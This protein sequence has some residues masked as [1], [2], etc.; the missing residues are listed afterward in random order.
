MLKLFKVELLLEQRTLRVTEEVLCVQVIR[1]LGE[2]RN[3]D[4]WQ[5]SLYVPEDPLRNENPVA[6]KRIRRDLLE[7]EQVY[8]KKV[9]DYLQ[10]GYSRMYNRNPRGIGKVEGLFKDGDFYYVLQV[11]LPGR[12]YA[13]LPLAEPKRRLEQEL[14]LLKKVVK[15]VKGGHN[16]IDRDGNAAPQFIGD[17]KP[18]NFQVPLEEEELV[19]F[20]FDVYDEA[21]GNGELVYSS[22]YRP[23]L[24]VADSEDA[25]RKNDLT[26]IVLILYERL[27]V[28][29]SKGA[30]PEREEVGWARLPIGKY[31]LCDY[32]EAESDVRF[33][34]RKMFEKGLYRKY[35]SCEELE[36]DINLLLQQIRHENQLKNVP[37]EQPFTVGREDICEAID[38]RFEKNAGQVYLSGVAGIGKVTAALKYAF[39]QK[40]KQNRFSRWFYVE[41]R[42]DI[43]TTVVEEMEF[44][45][46]EVTAEDVD[47]ETV[48]Q[49][50][51]K[52]LRRYG[53]DTL[54]ILADFYDSGKTLK[55]LRDT[56]EFK[57]LSSMD[58]KLLFTTQYN[59]G[60][61]GIEV[62]SLSME[63]CETLFYQTAETK[64]LSRDK[65][66]EVIEAANRHTAV[67][68]R[69]ALV[70]GEEGYSPETALEVIG[71]MSDPKTLAAFKAQQGNC[72]T[73]GAWGLY[74]LEGVK[75]T[76]CEQQVL[77]FLRYAPGEKISLNVVGELLSWDPEDQTAVRKACLGLV[78]AGWLQSKRDGN[79]SMDPLI[80]SAVMAHPYYPGE[81]PL[82]IK[83]I[84]KRWLREKFSIRQRDGFFTAGMIR[85]LRQLLAD[86]WSDASGPGWKQADKLRSG[87][88]YA[89]AAHELGDPATAAQI[90]KTVYGDQNQRLLL[91]VGQGLETNQGYLIAHDG[92]KV[93]EREVI[94]A[95]DQTAG[96]GQ[97][98]WCWEDP[99]K[100]PEQGTFC[101]ISSV[102]FKGRMQGSGFGAGKMQVEGFVV[103]GIADRCFAQNRSLLKLRLPDGIRRI[104]KGAFEDC[105]ALSEI[106]IPTSVEAIDA[107]AFKNTTLTDIAVSGNI[108]NIGEGAFDVAGKLCSLS[109][110]GDGKKGLVKVN[111]QHSVIT[112]SLYLE[113]VELSERVFVIDAHVRVRRGGSIQMTEGGKVVRCRLKFMLTIM[114]AFTVYEGDGGASEKK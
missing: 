68:K 93:I 90:M 53:S 27:I 111:P 74:D 44:S 47:R 83:R 87:L 58:L 62:G 5:G 73:K 84:Y 1:K 78:S 11:Y 36:R 112:E 67:I 23:Y 72:S 110:R 19:Y 34:L 109:I 106:S 12:N 20:D 33:A 26:C 88:L 42:E 50:K 14:T 104:G 35:Q 100:S 56:K 71:L 31:I 105:T 41:F 57:D 97:A 81:T 66:R 18:E 45:D 65:V 64:D 89:A 51:M 15:I 46:Y 4:V 24:Q 16:N 52:F 79:I 55:E 25:R 10:S 70:M 99:E 91:L 30:L 59:L 22:R 48:Y 49:T 69:L 98:L 13:E 40:Q 43:R 108:R 17:I 113:N 102:T 96:T 21:T 29:T 54:L 101:M 28:Q 38:A 32:D 60:N 107:D 114:K 7:S 9:L 3:T 86:V 2:G 77:R 80:A 6:V 85:L 103:T 76:K 95:S 37:K 75:F 61:E 39:T 94:P 63:E 8:Q 82:E 92:R